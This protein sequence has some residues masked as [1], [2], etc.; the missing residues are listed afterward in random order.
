MEP[1]RQ[2]RTSLYMRSTDLAAMRERCVALIEIHHKNP[3]VSPVWLAQELFV[4]R[5][6]LDRAFSGEQ[7]VAEVLARRRLSQVVVIAARHPSIPMSAIAEHCGYG[8]Y[9]TFR[10]QCHRYLNRTPR[11][12]RRDHRRILAVSLAA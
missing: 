10:A 2:C 9:E 3:E 11:E 12:A 4:S 1:A 6:Q 5:R 8:T 7:G